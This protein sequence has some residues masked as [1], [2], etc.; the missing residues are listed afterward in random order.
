MILLCCLP[1]ANDILSRYFHKPQYCTLVIGCYVVAG[2][3]LALDNKNERQ[4]IQFGE[5]DFIK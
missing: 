4:L 1:Q 2:D 5:Q 3:H